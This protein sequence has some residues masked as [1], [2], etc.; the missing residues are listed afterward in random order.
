[1]DEDTA[2]TSQSLPPPT[3]TVNVSRH[4]DL[5]VW[6]EGEG[7]PVILIHGALIFSLLRRVAEELPAKGDY[8]AIWYHRRG[9][10][11]KSTESFDV[12]DQARD[13]V[14]ILDALEIDKAH[15]V[16]H[17]AGANYAL[18]LATLTSD[19]LS[20]VA[21][22]DFVLVDHIASGN[23]FLEAVIAPSME[24]AH[25]GDP[26]GA[27]EAFITALGGSEELMESALP[28]SWSTM[29]VDAPT[30]FELELP[31]FMAWNLDPANVRAIDVPVGYLT[32]SE[33][34]PFRETR[35]RL[36]EWLPNLAMLEIS[37]DDHFFPISAPDRAATLIDDWIRSQRAS[38]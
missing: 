7:T 11:G 15:V 19:R 1:M 25:A 33:L 26:E 18:E 12:A 27:A 36:Q 35:E 30:F 22:L 2:G 31:A 24:K 28:G 23:M 20:S 38:V 13:V 4:D 17:S 14:R 32:T 37:T 16:S 3:A 29:A 21:L 34:A 9:Y 8:Q 5:D 10:N 6:V